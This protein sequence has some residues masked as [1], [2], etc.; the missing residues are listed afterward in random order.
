MLRC[1]EFDVEVLGRGH[2]LHPQYDLSRGRTWLGG[3]LR[4]HAAAG[5]LHLEPQLAGPGQHLHNAHALEVGHLQRRG[6]RHRR[7]VTPL[8]VLGK[9]R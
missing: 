5:G 2:E 4:C 8:A 7:V 9:A 1:Q 6:G 3:L